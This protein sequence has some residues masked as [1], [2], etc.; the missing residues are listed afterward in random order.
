[1]TVPLPAA[2]LVNATRFRA[3]HQETWERLEAIV[4]RIEKRS[5]RALGEDDLL[6]LPVLYR[7]TLSSLSVVRE[8][9]LDRALQTYLEQ[10]CTR[11]YFQIY[12]APGTPWRQLGH[13]FAEGWPRAVASL[14][15]ETLAAAALGI[16]GAVLGYFLVRHDPAWFYSIIPTGLAE[17]RDPSA[18]AQALKEVLYG[19]KDSDPLTTF[20]AYLFTHN[21]QVALFAFA[22]G[23]AFAVPTALLL[24]YNGL[25]L[26][27]LVE[28]Y[29]AKGLGPMLGG[30]LIIHGSTELFAI[31]LAGAAGFRIGLAVGFPG[32]VSRLD[33]AVAAGRTG[34]TA[35]A[36]VVLMLLVAGLLEGI[37]RQTIELDW[38][39]YAIGATVFVGWLVYYYL[40]RKRDGLA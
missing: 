36:G 14:W 29:V 9:S 13:F 23:F 30:W 27:A 24:V 16:L 35:M 1:V 25:T 11:A 2:P 4:G 15:R 39:R 8:T 22:L 17:G 20:A 26:G 3:A 28:I 6:A 5:V 37:G 12:G 21:A 7:T 18:S 19:S 32:R 10:L 34:G 33:S 38:E 31:T 40:P